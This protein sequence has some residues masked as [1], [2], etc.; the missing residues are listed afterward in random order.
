MQSAGKVMLNGDIKDANGTTSITSTGAS[1][2]QVNDSALIGGASITLSATKGSIGDAGTIET[3]MT[4]GGGGVDRHRSDDDQV[5]ETSGDLVVN[6]ATVSNTVGDHVSLSAKGSILGLNAT[7]LVQGGAIT[8][9]AGGA[10]DRSGPAEP[11]ACSARAPSRSTSTRAT[12][13]T[14]R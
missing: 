1:I 14:T 9:T 3:N 13:I 5:D 8:L 4:N 6:K 11:R 12:A 7:N 10:V 2:E